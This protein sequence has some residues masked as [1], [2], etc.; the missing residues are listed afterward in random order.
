MN[1][2]DRSVAFISYASENRDKAEQ[3]CASLEGR[4]LVCWMAPRDVRAG[5]EYADEIMRGLEGTTS[6]VLVLSEA[7]NASAF[8]RREVERAV[9]KRKPIFPVR[10]EEVTPAPGLELFISSTHW[11]DAW[12]GNWDD[13]MEQLA[14]G[15]ADG[16][17]RAE[18]RPQPVSRPRTGFS[19]TAMYAAGAVLVIVAIGMA[20]RSF[21]G[22][23]RP[24][25]TAA[26]IQQGPAPEAKQE[27][28]IEAP[29]RSA[30]ET[31]TGVAEPASPPV[32]RVDARVPPPP[33][34]RADTSASPPAI[35]RRATEKTEELSALREDYDSL[36]IRGGAVSDTLDQLWE[37][38][39]PLAPRVDMV[40]HQRSLKAGLARAR[41]ALSE[42][43]AA[44]ARRI[45][46]G[47]RADLEALE[48]FLN[49]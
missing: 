42:N 35:Q 48:Q 4:G 10:I 22:E 25:A 37:D 41:T 20:L 45:L 2:S 3:I 38:M 8:V 36:S 18:P 21:L 47:V 17:G 32:A 9:S 16:A 24:T 46:S 28:S 6:I 7:A 13:H 40:T 12:T 43:N 15:L 5:R 23:A 26:P 44:D 14:R 33:K 1:P 39:K 29:Q 19:R 34:A 30:A 31:T 27:I 49:R 11:L